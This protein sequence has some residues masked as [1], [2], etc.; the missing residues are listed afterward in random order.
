MLDPGSVVDPGAE[1]DLVAVLDPASALGSTVA[2]EYSDFG[3]ALE[4]FVGFGTKVVHVEVF[5]R[6]IVLK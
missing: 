3:E 4:G 2:V 6:P 1:L 5:C